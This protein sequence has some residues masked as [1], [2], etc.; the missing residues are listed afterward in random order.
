MPAHSKIEALKALQELP[1]VGPSIA[2]DL[3]NLGMRQPQDLIG[4]D[5]ND[6]FERSCRLQRV[7]IDRCLLYVYRCAVNYATHRPADPELAKWWNWKDGGSAMKNQRR[8]AG[9]TSR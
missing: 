9:S 8:R 5:P 1:G 6:L 3:Y 7:T 4:H 2:R